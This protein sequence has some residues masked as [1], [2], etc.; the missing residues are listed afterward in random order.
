VLVSNA[1][2]AVVKPLEQI[3]LDEWQRS[4]AVTVTAPF[5]LIQ[6]LL[7]AHAGRAGVVNILSIAARRACGLERLLRVEVHSRAHAGRA[8]E[9]RSRG[10]RIINVPGRDRTAFWDA[11]AA[12]PRERV[13]APR[14]S[15]TPSRSRSSGRGCRRGDARVGDISVRSNLPRTP[16]GAGRSRSDGA[17]LARRPHAPRPVADLA[18]RRASMPRRVSTS[19][20]RA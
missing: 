20:P 5:L 7:R 11:V 13:I 8:E 6:R 4:L 18:C 16:A 9:T 15:P 10:V 12:W 3:A 17:C 19:G 2:G 1:G 14:R